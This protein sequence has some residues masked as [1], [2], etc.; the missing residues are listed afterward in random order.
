MK[1]LIIGGLGYLGSRFTEYLSNKRDVKITISSRKKYPKTKFNENVNLINIVWKKKIINNLVTKFDHIIFVAGF[2]AKDSIT[3]YKES[4]KFSKNSI[5]LL[6]DSLKKNPIKSFIF[7]STA[8]VYNS[9]LRGK[10][11]EKTKTLNKHPYALSKIISEKILIEKLKETKI[12]LKIIRLS[13]AIGYPVF[14]N[15]QVWNLFVNDIIRQAIQKKKVIIKSDPYTQRN[16]ISI[17][18]VCRII[19]H[20]LN[21]QN[22]L[23][24]RNIINFGANRSYTLDQMIKK[25]KGISLKNNINFEIYYKNK[26]ENKKNLDLNFCSNYLNNSSFKVKSN[27]NN[28]IDFMIKKV[29]KWYK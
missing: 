27:L 15:N 1:V 10:I 26:F 22:F 14:K 24:K 11:N 2:N 21:N 13:N 19:W 8:H 4:I 20:I 12:N 29:K 7:I 3:N 5:N 25:I 17:S 16:F 23:K 9:Q 18:E 28:E 6:T